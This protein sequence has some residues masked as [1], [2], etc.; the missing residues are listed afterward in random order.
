M[1][2]TAGPGAEP[3]RNT[4]RLDNWMTDVVGSELPFAAICTTGRSADG[5]AVNAIG[6]RP[7]SGPK[8]TC[9]LR[10]DAATELRQICLKRPGSVGDHHPYLS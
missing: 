9:T 3:T 2:V 10:I 8:P 4:G 1:H 7:A 6:A 5:A